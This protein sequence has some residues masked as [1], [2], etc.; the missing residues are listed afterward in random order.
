[1]KRDRERETER[2]IER[3]GERKIVLGRERVC[4]RDRSRVKSNLLLYNEINP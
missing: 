1:M 4:E 3:E 2:E